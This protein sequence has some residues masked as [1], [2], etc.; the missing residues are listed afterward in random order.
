VFADGSDSLSGEAG[1]DILDGGTGNDVYYFSRNGGADLVVSSDPSSSDDRITFDSSIKFDQLWFERLR[2]DPRASVIGTADRVTVENWYVG[3]TYQVD[4]F[5]TGDGKILWVA[6]VEQF[7]SAMAAFTAP[8]PGQLELTAEQH[9][10]LDAAG[11]RTTRRQGRCLM[12]SSTIIAAASDMICRG[13]HHEAVDCLQEAIQRFTTVPELRNNLGIALMNLGCWSEAEAAFVDAILLRHD[14]AEAHYNL[15]VLYMRMNKLA[16]ARRALRAALRLQPDL[17]Q[18]WLNLAKA[19]AAP[20]AGERS[21]DPLSLC[22]H[23]AALKPDVSDTCYSVGIE[24]LREAR[25]G[26][27]ETALHRATLISPRDVNI[28]FQYALAAILN[29]RWPEGWREYDCRWLRPETPPRQLHEPRWHGEALDGRTILLHS[30]QGLGDTIQFSR[31]A[32]TLAQAGSNVVVECQRPLVQ[33]LRTLAAGSPRAIDVV[34]QG[35]PL[36]A[37]D[38]HAPLMNLPGLLGL[39]TENTRTI[40]PYLAP[41]PDRVETWRTRLAR[42]PGLRV[43]IVWQGSPNPDADNGRSFPLACLEAIGTI[44]GVRLISLQKHHGLDQLDRLP[45]KMKVETLGDDFDSGPSAFLDAAA[46]IMSLD[47]VIAP[48]T[49]IVH[50]A[51]ALGRPVFVALRPVPDVRWMMDRADTPWYPTMRLFRR[52]D[53]DWTPVFEQIAKEIGSML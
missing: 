40:V 10:S 44:P 8:P 7:C 50:L 47:I 19:S 24:C 9:Q 43:G 51:G 12:Q 38:V 37:F 48:D 11:Q 33:L 39:T 23:A 29:G 32:I 1:D 53:E 18:G 6:Q 3:N 36:P 52:S 4:D 49:A 30:E 14:Y 17:W 46:L 27:A 45:A 28:R 35:D 21:P 13:A 26:E 20:D 2:N 5:R 41:Q 34:A 42:R 16:E 15:G 31:Y 25:I 22:R